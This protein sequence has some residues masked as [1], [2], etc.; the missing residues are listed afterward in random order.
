MGS[1][2]ECSKRK[3]GSCQSSKGLYKNCIVSLNSILFSKELQGLP[4]YTFPQEVEKKTPSL[5]R[6]QQ[7][8]ITKDHVNAISNNHLAQ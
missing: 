4:R 8:H 6:K 5:S 1:K 3:G 7:L 2:K